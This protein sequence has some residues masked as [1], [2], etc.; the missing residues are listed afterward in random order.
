MCENVC[1]YLLCVWNCC[2]QSAHH[3]HSLEIA[4]IVRLTSICIII[5]IIIIITTTTI[6][7]VM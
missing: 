5:I 6:A 1:I 3:I 7:Q 2:L 4:D